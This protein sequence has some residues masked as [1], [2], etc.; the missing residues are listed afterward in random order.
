MND[1]VSTS[2]AGTV[3]ITVNPPAPTPGNP[4][5]SVNYQTATA[6]T[7][8]ATGQGTITYAVTTQPT[9]GTLTG[10][11]PNLTYTP[12]GNYVG[13]D[14]FKYT[15]TNVGGSSQGTVSITVQPAPVV[16]VAQN[17]SAVVAFNTAT[18]PDYDGVAGGGNGHA[19]AY[20]V[21][22]GPACM[23]TLG[24]F[25]GAVGDLHSD[26]RGTSART[27]SRSRL[28]T[29]RRPALRLRFQLR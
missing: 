24:A 9:N 15:A 21:A 14:S 22:T 3:S 16:P 7:L 27:A 17:S 6:V 10:T 8:T 5:V 25:T 19:L 20:S 28:R 18:A 29:A 2:A 26:G 12:T 1:G 4:S 13:T 23:E 11:A